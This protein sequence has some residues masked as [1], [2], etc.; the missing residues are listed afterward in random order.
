[1]GIDM[2]RKGRAVGVNDGWGIFLR[3][4]LKAA[5]DR[6]GKNVA[7]IKYQVQDVAVE[8]VQIIRT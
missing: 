2:E 7:V 6:L 4:R 1:M 3:G 8:S 5:R